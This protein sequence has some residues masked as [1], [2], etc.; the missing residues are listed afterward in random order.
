M[1]DPFWI[2]LFFFFPVRLKLV[3]AVIK[4]HAS[5][6]LHPTSIDT[7]LVFRS[8]FLYPSINSSY[9]VLFFSFASSTVSSQATVSSNIII[10]FVDLKNMTISGRRFLSTM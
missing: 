9:F 5:N 6:P 4:R 8:F 1:L 10:S 2:A 7:H 3:M